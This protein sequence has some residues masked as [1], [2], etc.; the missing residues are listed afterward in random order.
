MDELRTTVGFEAEFEQG[1]ADVIREMHAQYGRP[2]VGAAELHRYHCDCD[3]C[4]NRYRFRGQHD[5]SCSGEIITNVMEDWLEMSDA[6]DI[7]Q[8]VAT[9]VDAVPGESSGFHVHVGR[10]NGSDSRRAA[11][12]EVMRYE[13]ALRALAAGRFSEQRSNNATLQDALMFRMRDTIAGPW[14]TRETSEWYNTPNFRYDHHAALEWVRHH[15]EQSIYK[16]MLL[17]AHNS[18][19][20][21]SN[22]CVHTRFH[23]WEF[24]FPNSTRSAWRMKMWVGLSAAFVNPT[25][26]AHLMNTDDIPAKKQDRGVSDLVAALNFVDMSTTAE[27]VQRQHTY[28]ENIRVGRIDVP[29]DFT[30][31]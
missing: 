30:T 28:M 16:N 31:V 10:P 1:A 13:P 15:P 18:N 5:S 29:L 8:K 22:L 24:R 2:I 4:G 23:T 9:D 26:T 19:D 17:E 21:H 3:D 14:A 20:R 12:F 7:L 27:L 11:F 25:F 6:A